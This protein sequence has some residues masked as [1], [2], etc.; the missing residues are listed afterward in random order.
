MPTFKDIV[1]IKISSEYFNE[2]PIF[3]LFKQDKDRIA[4]VFGRNGSGKST[5]SH[6]FVEYANAVM[7]R[8]VSLDL[9]TKDGSLYI[10]PAGR[11]TKVFVFNEDYINENVKFKSDG[12]DT[13]VLLGEQVDISDKIDSTENC[14]KELVDKREDLEGK[15]LEYNDKKNSKSPDFWIE[16]ITKILHNGWAET[17]GI[18]INKKHKRSTVNL[19]TIER[20]MGKRPKESKTDIQAD[21]ESKM[22]TFDST[23]SESVPI[24]QVAS[25][26]VFNANIL[27]DSQDSLNRTVSKPSLT[28]RES[29]LLS[30]FGID[31]LTNAKEYIS[32]NVNKICPKCLNII[33][34]EH[35][36]EIV[37]EINRII[38]R[39]SEEFQKELERL[40][41]SEIQIAEF[42][43][44]KNLDKQLYAELVSA[45][46]LLNAE[47]IKHNKI[48]ND[49]IKNPFEPLSYSLDDIS[50]LFDAVNNLLSQIEQKRQNYNKA[51]SDRTTLIGEL[52]KR[53]SELAYF[54]INEGYK[55]YKKVKEEKE[56][57]IDEIQKANGSLVLYR[58]ELERL[59]SERQNLKLAAETLNKE[60]QYIFYSSKRLSLTPDDTTKTYKLKVNGRAVKPS[61]ISSGERNALALCYFFADIANNMQADNPYSEPMFLV[62]DDPVSS[63]DFENKIGIMSF[64]KYKFKSVLSG[65]ESTK[66]IIMTHD[67]SFFM[68]FCKALDEL[69]KY[70]K[71]IGKD[72]TYQRLY[73]YNKSMKEFQYKRQNEYT[74]L[75]TEVFE[76]ANTESVDENNSIGNQLRRV[77][78]AFSTFSFKVGIDE[79]STKKEILDLLPT[80]ELKDYFENL[81]YRLVLHGESHFADTARFFPRTDFYMH[82]SP[83]EKQ[84]TAK[85][86][87]CFMYILNEPHIKSHLKENTTVIEKWIEELSSDEQLE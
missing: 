30:L 42:D 72:A 39:E 77:V 5:I 36:D 29:E 86:I 63:F 65:S 48:I 27:K 15:L 46:S 8:T 73:L 37:E 56:S 75:L 7:P 33:T 61:K 1:S 66:A 10:S 82:L 17:Q 68:D 52:T 12:L 80:Q 81:M 38:S 3:N 26:I 84:R 62:I 34:A 4:M 59:N 21:F 11:P 45:I 83:E 53:N 47:I 57:I 14:I 24:S 40:I 71:S 79:L 69:S 44:F 41:L 18:K 13:I 43:V 49:K 74:D 78:E 54:D 85:D 70:C 32:Q 76:F 9:I 60:L 28:D 67:I 22:T 31:D 25:Q 20:I 6:G 55:Q 87:L 51:I 23:D 16:K 64:L 19:D 50:K 58:E 2:S 35:R